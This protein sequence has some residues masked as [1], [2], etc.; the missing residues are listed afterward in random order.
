MPGLPVNSL[1]SSQ[2]SGFFYP[3]RL[4]PVLKR[5][6]WGGRSIERIL[7]K[8]LP[9]G[10]DYAESWEVTDH[11]LGVNS[12]LYGRF[13]GETLHFLVENYP[14]EMLGTHANLRRFPLLMKILDANHQLSVQ[15][16]PDDSLASQLQLSDGGKDE[17][18]V[19]LESQPDS[20]IYSGFRFP[21]TET[22][23]REAIEEGLLETLLYRFHPE[24]GQSLYLPAG[25]VHSLGAGVLV[26]EIQQSSDHTFR[27]YDWNRKN[28]QGISRPLH[29][30]EGLQALL[31]SQGKVQPQEHKKM[32]LVGSE[33]L[34]SCDKFVVRRHHFTDSFTV[35]GT[36]SAQ[37]LFV[38]QGKVVVS[39]DPA[40]IPLASGHTVVLPAC[41]ESTTL[42]PKAGNP[43]VILQFYVPTDI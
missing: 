5:A 22:I 26:A 39:G 24:P 2:C 19:I 28:A 3:L 7:G 4:N 14:E 43:C 30:E 41:L 15:V 1:R 38:V 31:Y 6:V 12:I 17:A 34:V 33:T 42:T 35:S 8:P 32:G 27:L 9:P 11:R 36:Q 37:I 20:F 18:W 40:G 16:H 23:I 13:A 29:V 21:V 25:T 10:D